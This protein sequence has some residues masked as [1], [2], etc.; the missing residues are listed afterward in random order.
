MRILCFGDSNTWGYISGTDHQ[1]YDENTRWTRLLGKYLGNEYEIIEEGLNSRTLNSNYPVEYDRPY[2]NG[3]EYFIPCMRTHDKV[4]MIIIML[5]TNDLKSFFNLSASDMLEHLKLYIDNVLN[6]KSILDGST[7]KLI[8]SGIAPIDENYCKAYYKG[9]LDKR[10]QYNA[11]SKELCDKLS[12]S[13]V[14][15]SDLQ[16]GLDG[17]H[18]LEISHQ[19][20]AEKLYKEIKQ[21]E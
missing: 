2:R 20:L 18:I 13:F 11:L 8:I 10:N 5:G 14:D 19:K 6:Y 15:N 21:Y 7:P 16:V 17:V 4:D 3:F 1:R 9:I 12:V